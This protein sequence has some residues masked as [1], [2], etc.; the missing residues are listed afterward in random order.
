[1]KKI[2]A[3]ILVVMGLIGVWWKLSTTT[4]VPSE[5][6]EVKTDKTPEEIL[7]G[8]FAKITKNLKPE[9]IKGDE[10]KQITNY[11]AKPETLVSRENAQGF[12][13]TAQNNIPDMYACLKKDFCGMTTR[14]E[15]DAY[16][17]DQRTPAHILINRNLKI[18]KESLRKDESLKSQVNWEMLHEL[19][20]SDAEMLQVEALDILR[21]FDSES[22][23]TDE[24]IKLTADYTG[25]AKA[26]ALLRI[27][28]GK[29]PSDKG[30][31]AQE[32]EEVFA[33]SDANTV[34]SVLENV[35]KMALG[36]ND[37]DRVFRNLCRFKNNPDEAHNWRMIKYEAG[38]VNPD[39]EKLCN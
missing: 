2:I 4:P 13:K 33:M 17:D 8:D 35:K 36:S 38:K 15:D 12:F 10:W 30:L 22:I 25:T 29:N 32:I 23:K 28:K 26:D 5:T 18:M 16:F 27:A 7:E 6:A 19:A 24:L 39:F 37:T 20:A 31:V 14:G 3:L 21:E 1:M 34:I 11:A 9:N